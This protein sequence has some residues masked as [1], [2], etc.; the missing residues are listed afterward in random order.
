MKVIGH[1]G[2]KGLAPENTVASL[3][4]AVECGVDRVEFD[5]RVTKDG[6]PVLH[7]SPEVYGSLVIKDSTVAE[8]VAAKP[9]LATFEGALDS[10]L[11]K[12]ALYV[13]VKPGVDIKPIVAIIDKQV[14]SQD[15][16]LA[17]FSQHTLRE[18]HAALPD[19]PVVILERWSG[20]RAGRRA[21][22]LDTKLVCMKQRWLW[23]GFISSVSRGGWQLYAYTVN[24]PIQARKW[25]KHGLAGIVTDYP[26]RFNR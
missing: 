1:R 17:S 6:I 3:L 5:L 11:G 26:D 10:L 7:H 19:I 20:V 12:V 24:N 25:A 18:L 21:R 15:V 14:S 8:L 9:D 4:K 16:W 2:A 22:E 13:E 23:W